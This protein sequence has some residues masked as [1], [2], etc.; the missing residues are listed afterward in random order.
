MKKIFTIL[1]LIIVG[2]Y[3][4]PQEKVDTVYYTFNIVNP[5]N[6]ITQ[7]TDNGFFLEG[8]HL[9]VKAMT[10]PSEYIQWQNV[11]DALVGSHLGVESGALDT[12]I[13]LNITFNKLSS[14]NS[15]YDPIVGQTVFMYLEVDVLERGIW[16]QITDHFYFKNGKKAFMNIPITAAFQNF[17]TSIGINLN[18]GISFAY[19]EVDTLENETWEASGLS[20]IK[21]MDT[22]KLSLEH[23]SKFGGGKLLSTSV[24]LID[25]PNGF[26]LKQ[27][28]PN[29]FN[30]LTNIVYSIPSAGYVEIKLYN[31]IGTEVQTLIAERKNAGTYQLTLN[32][33]NLTS[34]IYYYTIRYEKNQ[35]TR[36]MVL[37]K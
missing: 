22:I 16:Y 2:T 29:P 35:L 26:T 28:Y 11:Y 33:N 3:L 37:I 4:F 5:T 19:L 18:E 31:A 7:Q 15:S 10:L 17:C 9:T 36:K 20:W 14:V 21:E 32:A 27:N 23:F 1:F 34:G 13:L 30:P 6:G 25:K 24:R 12:N 8:N